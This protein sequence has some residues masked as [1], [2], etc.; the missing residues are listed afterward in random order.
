MLVWF[1]GKRF[2]WIEMKAVMAVL[3]KHFRF[4]LNHRS[5][6]EIEMATDTMVYTSK[7]GIYLN[8]ERI[9]GPIDS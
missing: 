7:H 8:L 2:A 3:L 1:T 6:P 9:E 4:T 5:S